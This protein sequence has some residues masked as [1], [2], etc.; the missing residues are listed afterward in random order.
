MKAKW[1]QRCTNRGAIG[2]ARFRPLYT[3]YIIDAF[4]QPSQDILA[5]FIDDTGIVVWTL[6]WSVGPC[7][8]GMAR[9]QDADGGTAS[10]MEGSC[11]YIE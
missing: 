5:L 7:H 2:P 11:E 3:L 10:N 9:P 6:P 8:H 1:K 4:P